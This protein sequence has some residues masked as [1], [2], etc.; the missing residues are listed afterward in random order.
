MGSN[1]EAEQAITILALD[2]GGTRLRAGLGSG[3]TGDWLDRRVT[4]SPAEGSAQYDLKLMMSLLDE[5]L[6]VRQPAAVG[7]SFGGPID[8]PSGV[9]LLSHHVAGWENYPL[10]EYLGNRLGL[11]IGVDNDA[12]LGAYGEFK[13]GAGRQKKNICYITISTGVGSGW[14]LGGEIYRGST[15]LAGEIG[16][17]VID[18]RGPVC[19]CG[20]RGC[21]E[22]LASGPYIA[23]DYAVEMGKLGLEQEGWTGEKVAGAAGMGERIALRL[24]TRSAWAIGTAVGNAANLLNPDCFILGG[25]VTLSGESWWETVRM[26]ADQIAIPEIRGSFDIVPGQLGDDS[27]LKG[28]LALGADYLE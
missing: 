3:V 20:K 22:R 28:A 27:P 12:N 8:Y 1:D 2:F 11:P 7:V 13:F 24:L 17:T 19:L 18:P 9:V 15:S 5:L 16:H 10:R 25:G 26:T 21:V 23:Q 14:I 6:E 4:E